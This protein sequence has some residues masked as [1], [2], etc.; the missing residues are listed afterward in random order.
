MTAMKSQLVLNKTVLPLAFMDAA[1]RYVQTLV[2][3]LDKA[4]TE[5]DPEH[6]RRINAIII[7][8]IIRDLRDA[9]VVARGQ[10][11]VSANRGSGG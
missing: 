8:I 2:V 9:R 7:E 10:H 6:A 5:V 1:I 4:G 11:R 3:L